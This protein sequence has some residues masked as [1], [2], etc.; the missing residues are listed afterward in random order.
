MDMEVLQHYDTPMMKHLLLLLHPW[1]KNQT[2]VL[3][4]ADN[5]YG[6]REIHNPLFAFQTKMA[7]VMTEQAFFAVIRER[8]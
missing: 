3:L 2:W 1:K 6:H 4:H 8:R 5:L 7:Y